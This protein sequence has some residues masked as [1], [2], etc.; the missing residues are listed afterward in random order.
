[1]QLLKI[2]VCTGTCNFCWKSNHIFNSYIFNSYISY[3]ENGQL[4]GYSPKPEIFIMG[5]FHSWLY[6]M[7]LS[8]TLEK[9]LGHIS[10][11]NDFN[12]IKI[13]I[14]EWYKDYIIED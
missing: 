12:I 10:N 11:I 1:M 7:K 14:S 8:L 6:F 2:N 9:H 4:L 5:D 3:N 13:L